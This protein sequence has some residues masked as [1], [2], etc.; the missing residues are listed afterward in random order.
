MLWI[1]TQNKEM[2]LKVKG[3]YY[4]Y[5][6]NKHYITCI[7][8]DELYWVGIYATKERALEVL[9]EIQ[10]KIECYLDDKLA[11]VYEMPKD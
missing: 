10:E 9:D 5:Q 7:T 2:L 8:D 1:R 3:I 4:D 6:Q 11:Y